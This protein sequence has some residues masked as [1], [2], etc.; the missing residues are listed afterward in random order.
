MTSVCRETRSCA[1]PIV[2]KWM[3]RLSSLVGGGKLC[4][5]AAVPTVTVASKRD[6]LQSAANAGQGFVKRRSR[7]W[8]LPNSYEAN[9]AHSI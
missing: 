4:W 5:V 3:L 9:R 7:L 8:D 1:G 2:P 6:L